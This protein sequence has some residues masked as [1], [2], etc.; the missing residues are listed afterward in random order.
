MESKEILDHAMRAINP[1]LNPLAPD[2][3]FKRGLSLFAYNGLLA[4][5]NILRFHRRQGFP[6]DSVDLEVVRSALKWTEAGHG[7]HPGHGVHTWGRRRARWGRHA[8]NT[9]RRPSHG[10]G[11][12][13]CVETIS[14]T[15]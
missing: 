4:F 15:K 13:G 3:N 5:S 8:R 2:T 7:N 9:G 11:F 14:S 6:V 12:G 10:L 1:Q